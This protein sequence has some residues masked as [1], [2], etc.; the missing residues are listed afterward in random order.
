MGILIAMASS[1]KMK[2]SCKRDGNSASNR[3]QYASHADKKTIASC[4]NRSVIPR[5]RNVASMNRKSIRLKKS[6]P[7]LTTNHH[8]SIFKLSEGSFEVTLESGACAHFLENEHT[9]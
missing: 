9:P 3:I 6:K 4:R 8:K 1:V 5:K 2:R 7:P